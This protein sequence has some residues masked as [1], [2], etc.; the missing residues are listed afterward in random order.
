L[1][2]NASIHAGI[3]TRLVGLED[4]EDDVTAGFALVHSFDMDRLGIEKISKKIRDRI[5]D[6]P[7]YISLDID[8]L[9]PSIAPASECSCSLTSVFLIWWSD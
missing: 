3:R 9:D 5:G 6:G 2:P 8:V 7:V 1:R 4:Y